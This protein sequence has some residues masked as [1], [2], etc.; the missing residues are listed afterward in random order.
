MPYFSTDAEIDISVDDFLYECSSREINE[1]I[2]AL[3]EDE[4]IHPSALKGKSTPQS[5]AEW[6]FNNIIDKIASNRLQLTNEEDELLKKIASR[7]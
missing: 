7:F 5:L 3:V 6:E 2:E 4:H 1:L